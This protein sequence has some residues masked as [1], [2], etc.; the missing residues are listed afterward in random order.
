MRRT[1]VCLAVLLSGC[2]TP[3][4]HAW[5]KPGATEQDFYMERGQCNAQGASHAVVGSEQLLWIFASC[6]QGKGWY[7]KPIAQ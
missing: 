4:E 2:A 3:Q 5:Y 7:R 1:I 6:M